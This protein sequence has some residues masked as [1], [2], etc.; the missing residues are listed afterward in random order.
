LILLYVIGAGI[1]YGVKSYMV[2]GLRPYVGN[3]SVVMMAV[4]LSVL[5]WP[6]SAIVDF[7]YFKR[8]RDIVR[9]IGQGPR[10]NC[11]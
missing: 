9:D 3:D 8:I 5:L 2:S 10:G 4:V 7:F 6:I 11:L 1:Y